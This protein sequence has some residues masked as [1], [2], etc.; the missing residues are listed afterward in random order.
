MTIGR[1]QEGWET[2]LETAR[3]PLAYPPL[4][5]GILT[6]SITVPDL[7]L[8]V[9][10][11]CRMGRTPAPRT[12]RGL[13]DASALAVARADLLLPAYSLVAPG[14]GL[15]TA[16]EV[17]ECARDLLAVTRPGV[18]AHRSRYRSRDRRRSHDRSPSTDRSLSR[19][20][21]WRP[22]RGHRDRAEATVASRDRGDSGL[23]V[24]P[25][26]AVAGDT[27]ALPTSSFLDLVRRVLSLSGSVEQRG[28]VLGSL[29]STAAV[30][31]AGDVP[32]P[33]AP[34]PTA[35]AVAC[36]P[37]V[38]APGGSTS[39]CAASATASPGRCESAQESSRPEQR[40][41]RST[42]WERSRSGG[43]R[44][45]GRSP[46]PARF[47]RSASASASSSS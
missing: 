19:K 37:S 27:T 33:T 47:A 35:A 21:S 46:S 17:N 41:G 44:G 26:P 6:W 22:G 42:G 28:A 29:L 36:S 8:E 40:H 16:L 30:T 12:V 14:R 13:V 4:G 32:A 9:T 38:P 34:V 11:A 5:V 3:A 24:A 10:V 2:L 15:R 45:R 43:K 31:G 23:T 7:G 1:G 20:R 25:A 39:A 18:T